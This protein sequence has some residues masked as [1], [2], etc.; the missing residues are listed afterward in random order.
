MAV[1]I[2]IIGRLGADSE[3]KESK[4]GHKYVTFRIACNEYR[5]NQEETSWFNVFD[6]SERALKMAQY[7]KKGS[8]LQVFGT[9]TVRIYQNQNGENAIGRD[10]RA[11]SVDFVNA[12]GNSTQVAEANTA[13]Q[14][15]AP[16]TTAQAVATPRSATA[17]TMGTFAPPTSQAPSFSTPVANTDSDDLPF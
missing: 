9:E 2:N 14:T 5:N 4:L 10:I 16:N 11:Y 12:G 6:Y 17:P 8:M 1:N 7:W 15:T 3:I 13:A